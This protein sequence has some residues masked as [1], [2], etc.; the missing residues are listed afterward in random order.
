M[1]RI[2]PMPELSLMDKTFIAEDLMRQMPNQIELELKHYFCNGICARELFVPKGVTLV[3]KIHKYPQMHLIT[4]GLIQFSVGEEV[5]TFKASDI[6]ISPPGSKRIAHALEDTIWIMFLRTDETDID[7][8][9]DYFVAN[10]Q[11]EYLEFVN[12]QLALPLEI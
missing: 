11:E 10:S 1:D 2:Q 5:K 4:K 7:K 12:R 8:I 3:G 6:I 9:E